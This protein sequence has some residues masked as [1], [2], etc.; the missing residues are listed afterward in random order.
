MRTTPYVEDERSM[1]ERNHDVVNMPPDMGGTRQP[2]QRQPSGARS[3][4]STQW[5]KSARDGGLSRSCP[6]VWS[7]PITIEAL[8][9]RLQFLLELEVPASSAS[10]FP[11][12]SVTIAE[13]VKG[14]DRRDGRLIL[15]GDNFSLHLSEDRIEAVCVIRRWGID[16]MCKVL[17]LWSKNGCV[18]DY[19]LCASQCGNRRLA[20]RDGQLDPRPGRNRCAMLSAVP[21]RVIERFVP[22]G[23]WRHVVRKSGYPCERGTPGQSGFASSWNVWRATRTGTSSCV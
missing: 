12:R 6:I 22:V 15:L 19:S 16:K 14:L 8:C 11:T 13:L 23:A 20:G 21:I 2:R 1:T 4:V 7:N 18:L 3:D 10:L 5:M 17:E 9:E